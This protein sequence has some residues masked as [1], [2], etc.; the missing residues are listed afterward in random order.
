MSD[1]NWFALFVGLSLGMSSQPA[2]ASACERDLVER[3][4]LALRDATGA[5]AG[6]WQE[7]M[8]LSAD[9]SSGRAVVNGYTNGRCVYW[10]R[11][12]G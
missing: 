6:Q 5:D 11:D 9:F 10:E 3:W 4:A 8:V 12:S 7:E 1:A 2:N